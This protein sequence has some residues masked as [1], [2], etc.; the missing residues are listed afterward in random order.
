MSPFGAHSRQWHNLHRTGHNKT[1]E[2]C[3]NRWIAKIEFDV[4]PL[5]HIS[6]GIFRKRNQFQILCVCILCR[7][8]HLIH[9]QKRFHGECTHCAGREPCDRNPKQETKTC[10]RAQCALARHPRDLFETT[11]ATTTNPWQQRKTR[12]MDIFNYLLIN[13]NQIKSIFELADD[14]GTQ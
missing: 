6:R 5:L 13:Q 1:L 4:K 8:F 11:P 14:V 10:R 7:A 3:L 12:T 9:C 2:T